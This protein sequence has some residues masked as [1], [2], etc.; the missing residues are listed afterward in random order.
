[1][2]KRFASL[3]VALVMGLAL[4][5]AAYTVKAQAA[6]G[7]ALV[8]QDAVALR[9]AARDSA[10]AQAQLWR[11]EALEI[12]GERLDYW[13]VYDYRRERGGYVRKTQLLRTHVLCVDT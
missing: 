4:L 1:M 3:R 6:S 5:A 9:A 10:P 13:Q 8:L 7:V 2:E 11:G 12:R